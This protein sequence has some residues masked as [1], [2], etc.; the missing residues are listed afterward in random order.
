MA[1]FERYFSFEKTFSKL[2]CNYFGWAD[3]VYREFMIK[4]LA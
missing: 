3:E 4:V 1:K 2:K